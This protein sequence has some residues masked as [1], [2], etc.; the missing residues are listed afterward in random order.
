[1]ETFINVFLLAC[2]VVWPVLG[3]YVL[4]K[5]LTAQR[6]Q[7]TRIFPDTELLKAEAFVHTVWKVAIQEERRTSKL[8]ELQH[9]IRAA[10]R[11]GNARLN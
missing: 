2:V 11:I 3:A 4:F 5:I 8:R 9:V 7:G 1:M 6:N 10:C